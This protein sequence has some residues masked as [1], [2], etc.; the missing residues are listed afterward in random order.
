MHHDPPVTARQPGCG[1]RGETPT[2]VAGCYQGDS[3]GRSPLLSRE[4]GEELAGRTGSS[5][6]D[7]PTRKRRQWRGTLRLARRTAALHLCASQRRGLPAGSPRNLASLGLREHRGGDRRGV[8]PVQLHTGR[9]G[10][11]AAERNRRGYT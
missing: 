5:A 9:A 10:R 8:W 11:Q 3:M 4:Q 6:I 2:V 1:R 7:K